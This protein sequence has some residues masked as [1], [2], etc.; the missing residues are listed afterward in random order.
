MEE[1]KKE[2]EKEEEEE[3]EEEE[4]KEQLN[5]YVYF[6][7]NKE[8]YFIVIRQ[9]HFEVFKKIE[10]QSLKEKK[11]KMVLVF[12]FWNINESL[13]SKKQEQIETFYS[14]IKP[15]YIVFKH[16]VVGESFTFFDME[17]LKLK[18]LGEL[19]K[20]EGLYITDELY[21][22]SP[23][24]SILF[25]N[26][27]TKKLCVKKIKINSKRQLSNFFD[28][29]KNTECEELIL[30]D[31]FI[32]LL[33][34]EKEDDDNELKQYFS[35]KDGKI[36]IKE[37]EKIFNASIKKLKLI[38]CP[39]FA[40]P[41][42][43]K[44]FKDINN[45]KDISIDI[46]EN[47]LLNPEMITKFKINEGLIDICYDL[48]SYKVNN[49]E[50][51]EKDYLEHIK[52]IFEII[53]ENIN[54]YRKIKFKNFDITKYEYVTGENYTNIDE[55]DWVLNEEENNKKIKYE[56]DYK[57]IEEKIKKSKFQNMKEL[58]FNN[59][60]NNFMELI[61]SMINNDLDL[62]KLKKCAK[63]FFK[64]EIIK[65]IYI[66]HLFLFDTPIK[67][68][69]L[70]NG[71]P[72]KLTL[73][74]VTLGHYCQ[75]NNL[76]YYKAMEHIRTLICGLKKTHICFEMNALP[77]LMTFL[78]S[79]IV[80]NNQETDETPKILTYFPLNL[81]TKK[82]EENNKDNKKENNIQNEK[83]ELFRKNWITNTKEF[84]YF[85]GKEIIL[86][87]N[88]IRNKLENYYILKDELKLD[89]FKKED[90]N[91]NKKSDFG[92]DTA[93][94]DEDY[95][96]FFQKNKIKGIILENCLFIN[97]KNLELKSEEVIKRLENKINPTFKNFF[98]KN[99][100]YKIDMKTLKELIFNLNG[101][102]DFA[103][104][105]K[106]YNIFEEKRKELELSDNEIQYF[107]D[108][109]DFSTNLKQL[110]LLINGKIT[111]IINNIIELKELYCL[112][113]LS[114]E[115]WKSKTY[116]YKEK[117]T[118]VPKEIEIKIPRDLINKKI[119]KYF[120][121]E[122]NE[123][124][125]FAYTIF[126]YYYESEEE[127]KFFGSLKADEKKFFGGLKDYKADKKFKIDEIKTFDDIKFEIEYN[128]DD[129]WKI[130][131][132]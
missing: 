96:S 81:G 117:E 56:K 125:K 36:I 79:E 71:E 6:L 16:C 59:C 55:S 17:K 101:I 132:E 44:S 25:K 77:I 37:D 63:D 103:I 62:F 115:C 35:Y 111:I 100:K 39:L 32:E 94:L 40:L 120:V 49:E 107:S 113:H 23:N 97:F 80:Y 92:R 57:D 4:Q 9:I 89:E 11:K 114:F 88:S 27:K 105:M 121:K 109:A 14:K 85:K 128:Y 78:M 41:E 61:L 13:D 102:N 46:D 8:M 7:E 84:E 31:I 86:K 50:E 91:K 68:A 54:N 28:F 118:K 123:D 67:F 15:K 73:K 122:Y 29:I 12:D 38:D 1:D 69:D 72:D 104:I 53:L 127:K 124:N 43:D 26:V 3:E 48:D 66:K 83:N 75:E 19:I 126:N 130:I 108:Y 93:Y 33:I 2:E 21:S 76:D 82:K 47:S 18:G 112:I 129:P 60:A 65:N 5:D 64:I 131:F 87:R 45:Y 99:I 90:K 70:K 119:E 34:K 42:G 116:K 51:E 52:Y 30:D 95:K 24:L 20:L 58:I 10:N 106:I 110:F 22:M 74:I 98:D